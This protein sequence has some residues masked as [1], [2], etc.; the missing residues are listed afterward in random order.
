MGDR[1]SLIH[2]EITDKKLKNNDD[3]VWAI[4]VPLTGKFII[5]VEFLDLKIVPLEGGEPCYEKEGMQRSR[6]QTNFKRIDLE[7]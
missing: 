6:I 4:E 1:K 5:D 7:L 3:F 2:P